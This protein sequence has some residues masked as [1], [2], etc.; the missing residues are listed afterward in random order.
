ME[1]SRLLLEVNLVTEMQHMKDKPAVVVVGRFN[2]LTIGHQA[3]IRS[4]KEYADQN[5]IK[6]VIVAIVAAESNSKN[7]QI[8]PLSGVE[9]KRFIEASDVAELIDQILVTKDAFNA[10]ASV[11]KS[12][13]EPIAVAAGPERQQSYLNIL[14]T[15][16]LDKAGKPIKHFA[17]PDIE[18]DNIVANGSEK[19][20]E[21]K[22]KQLLDKLEDGQDIEITDV[23]STLV[24][25]A[26]KANKH[27]IFKKL[28]GFINNPKIGNQ[29]FELVKQRISE[30]K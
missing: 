2:P 15:Y 26:A 18:R 4:A 27:D 12:G 14:D 1:V 24:K 21:E 22:N 9:R 5:N 17:V 3:M 28:T 25:M 23:S 20:K 11:R 6:H 13:Y 16:F 30:Q 29:M 8:N 10:L 7:T 19:E